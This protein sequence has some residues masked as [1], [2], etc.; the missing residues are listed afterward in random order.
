MDRS[1]KFF[2]VFGFLSL[3]FLLMVSC[4]EEA[5][6]PQPPC[7]PNGIPIQGTD[8]CFCDFW[9]EGP[10]CETEIR[11]KFIGTWVG[12]NY[13]CAWGDTLADGFKV[14]I[15]KVKDERWVKIKSEDMFTNDSIISPVEF[16]G[17]L[18]YFAYEQVGNQIQQTYNIDIYHQAE[19]EDEEEKLLVFIARNEDLDEWTENCNCELKR[20]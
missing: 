17:F 18:R 13:S 5:E 3:F 14:E 9:Y 1:I 12:H 6:P 11:E 19:E 16:I 4:S 15:S 20:E 8:D 7:G 10:Q 2:S